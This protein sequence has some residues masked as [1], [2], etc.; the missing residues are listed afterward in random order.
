MQHVI[1]KAVGAALMLTVV[2][3]LPV[4]AQT[5]AQ[6]AVTLRVSGSFANNGEFAGTLTINRFEARGDQ[7]FAVGF[8]QGTLRRGNRLIGTGL[9]GEHSWPVQVSVAAA[10]VS[11]RGSYA[12]PEMVPAVWSPDASGQARIIPVQATGCTPVS[13][14]LGATTVNILGLNVALDPVGLVVTGAAG[15]ALGGL[16]CQ[17]S[18]LLGNVTGLVGVLNNI[19]S[20]LTGLLGGLTGGLAA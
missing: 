12:A 9:T 5:A 2:G 4:A 17:V 18:T 6:P 15:S 10:A 7:I 1:R 14:N 19:L 16:V 13:I 3:G 20:L 8:V 11:E